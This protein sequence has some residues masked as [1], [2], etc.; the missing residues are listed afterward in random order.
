M[1]LPYYGTVPAGFPSP[2]GDYME[3]PIDLNQE[4]VKRPN[5]TFYFRCK[6]ESMT[7]AF[8]PPNAILVVDRVEKVR[9]GSI[10]LAVVNQE[11]TVKR[12]VMK[13]GR[14]YLVPENPKY[15]ALEI[16]DGMDFE[17]W[18]VITYI[19]SNAKEV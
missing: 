1:L 4:I 9:S 14:H 13:G 5:A 10:V 17:V 11:Y 18:G 15:K 6:G 3:E 8:I 12:L 16:T 19:I 7:G 2:A